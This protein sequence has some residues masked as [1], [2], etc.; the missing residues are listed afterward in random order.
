MKKMLCFCFLFMLLA[1]S[2]S[3][4][5]G[6]VIGNCNELMTAMS[7]PPATVRE[8]GLGDLTADAIRYCA[9]SNLA[10]VPASE[11]AANLQ[12][13]NLTQRNIETV[14]PGDALYYIATVSAQDLAD[15]ILASVSHT[16][17]TES[18][19]IDV[20]ASAS[21]D[22]LQISGFS[23]RY[24]PNRIPT[25]RLYELS[26]D[27][28]AAD[29]QNTER[30]YTLALPESMLSS[31]GLSG[32]PLN[33]TACDCLC[34]YVQACGNVSLPEGNR[35][36]PIAIREND[37]INRFPLVLLAFAAAVIV[38]SGKFFLKSSNA[39]RK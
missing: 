28:K 25:D 37:Y 4:A 6:E 17:L 8:T 36:Y 32:K 19:S 12:P 35:I 13:G 2:A 21:G 31:L 14:L 5:E 23:F 39:K 24:D 26:I 1:Q 30:I 18:G 15:M 22:F 3:A 16:V 9:N 7:D 38:V 34:R 33:L 29:P 11:F 27:G 10:I 20:T